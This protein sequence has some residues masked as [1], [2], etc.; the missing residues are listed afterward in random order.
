VSDSLRKSCG[1]VPGIKPG[2]NTKDYFSYI[3]SR[4]TFLGAFY[5]FAV[6]LAVDFFKVALNINS[7]VGGTS[8]LIIT[9]IALELISKY[10]VELLS[11]K[12][13]DYA[14]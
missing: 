11:T 14:V 9:V 2:N 1:V 7:F 4:L 13:N 12:Y 5:L 6:S 3:L 8:Y 10:Q